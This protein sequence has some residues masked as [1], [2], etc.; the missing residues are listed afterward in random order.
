[1]A[2]DPL[3]MAF[4]MDTFDLRKLDISKYLLPVD[5]LVVEIVPKMI[6]D[7]EM[8]VDDLVDFPVLY[9]NKMIYALDRKIEELQEIIKACKDRKQILEEFSEDPIGYINREV[10]INDKFFFYDPMVQDMI[11]KLM[12]NVK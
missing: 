12:R 10:V 11:F 3:K 5:S 7:V 8:E 9:S 1:M 6:F 2:D 4:N